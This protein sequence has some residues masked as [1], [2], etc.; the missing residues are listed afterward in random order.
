MNIKK[1]VK[2]YNDNAL[3]ILKDLESF[4][5]EQMEKNFPNLKESKD[6]NLNKTNSYS[7]PELLELVY[8]YLE[9]GENSEIVRFGNNRFYSIP[10]ESLGFALERDIKGVEVAVPGEL[11]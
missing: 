5:R 10:N 3:F 7:L 9:N 2:R 1:L 4:I 11:S 6:F 8:D